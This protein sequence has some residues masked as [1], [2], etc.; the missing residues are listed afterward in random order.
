MKHRTP[1]FNSFKS[2]LHRLF[3]YMYVFL[4]CFR[5]RLH[6]PLSTVPVVY[7]T[8]ILLKMESATCAC[9]NFLSK[10]LTPA[11]CLG[12]IT[13]HPW[14]F[15]A[16]SSAESRTTDIVTSFF[17][18]FYNPHRAG[19][20]WTCVKILWIWEK[21]KAYSGNRKKETWT[22]AQSP[23]VD[24]GCCVTGKTCSWLENYLL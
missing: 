7:A 9:A 3:T 17:I 8:A 23:E 12:I 10:N 22:V 21:K 11:N 1:K 6:V 13:T 5:F 16:L 19:N 15:L 20:W 24:H 4:L 18:Q 2:W 14:S